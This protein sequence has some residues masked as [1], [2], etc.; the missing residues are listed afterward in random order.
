M[1][2]SAL[3][4]SNAGPSSSA[5]P[6]E[7]TP[8]L[9]ADASPT[10]AITSAPHDDGNA[11]N[12]QESQ[13]LV[14]D[15]RRQAALA[16]VDKA[17]KKLFSLTIS[18]GTVA[19]AFNIAYMVLQ[20]YGTEMF[21]YYAWDLEEIQWASLWTVSY[22]VSLGPQVGQHSYSTFADN[23]WRRFLN[24]Q[25]V[26][27]LPTPPSLLRVP[28]HPSLHRRWAPHHRGR[29]PRSEKRRPHRH[30]LPPRPR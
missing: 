2:P 4:M 5:E 17:L 8:L 16:R 27:Q 1:Q 7:D 22:T 29:R 21:G 24:L 26:S 9:Q 23:H 28:Q 14:D 15:A 19:V 18:T 10:S 30:P 12:D 6:R 11:Q 25:P 20:R 3:N 13:R